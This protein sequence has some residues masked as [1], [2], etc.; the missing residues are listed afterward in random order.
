MFNLFVNE[1]VV[2]KDIVGNILDLY[3]WL[4]KST[5][6]GKVGSSSRMNRFSRATYDLNPWE[7]KYLN[8]SPPQF[9]YMG[10]HYYSYYLA[11]QNESPV[12]KGN[13][14]VNVTTCFYFMNGRSLKPRF[15]H[16]NYD[17]TLSSYYL[18]WHNQQSSQ[19]WLVK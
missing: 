9:N 13:G 7:E 17:D 4:D 6:N 5:F 8:Y 12:M 19:Y 10:F 16:T 3:I 15:Q 11:L 18:K 2:I 1:Y 14:T